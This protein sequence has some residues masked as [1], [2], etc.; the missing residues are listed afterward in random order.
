MSGHISDDYTF[1]AAVDPEPD[2]DLVDGH[3]SLGGHT[4]WTVEVPQ[5][6]TPEDVMERFA[7]VLRDRLGGQS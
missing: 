3:V 7:A 6:T 5:G 1:W 2:H 4:V